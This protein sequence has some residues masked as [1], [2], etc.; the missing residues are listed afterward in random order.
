VLSVIFFTRFI[1]KRFIYKS[2]GL[3]EEGV[4]INLQLSLQ[5]CMILFL[6]R[7]KNACARINNIIIVFG[8]GATPFWGERGIFQILG[9]FLRF[10]NVNGHDTSL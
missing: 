10:R 2:I 9:V 1:Y 4:D 8:T 6:I 3:N 7:A 5:I